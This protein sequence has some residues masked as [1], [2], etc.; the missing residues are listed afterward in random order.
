MI[1]RSQ[2]VLHFAVS[3]NHIL[4]CVV[5]VIAELRDRSILNLNLFVEV[6][7]LVLGRFNDTDDLLE[8]P[9]LIFE[10]VFLQTKHLFIVKI[11]SLVVLAILTFLVASLLMG[12]GLCSL[13]VLN[14]T[15]LL[16]ETA[17]DQILNIV[18]ELDTL[19]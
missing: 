8:L 10:Q 5:N 15:I 17:T 2:Q 14:C 9:V 7:C 19:G 6:L 1:R 4:L 11:S 3:V 13:V 16:S 18:D 12:S